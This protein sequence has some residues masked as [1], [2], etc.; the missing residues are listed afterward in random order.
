MSKRKGRQRGTRKKTAALPELASIISPWTDLLCVG[1]LSIVLMIFLLAYILPGYS[2]QRGSGVNLGNVLLLQ[3]LINWPHFMAS[4]RLLYTS[5]KNI[6]HY[7]SSAIYVPVALLLVAGVALFSGEGF[8]NGG[9]RINQEVTYVVWLVAAFYLAWHYTGQAWG[10]IATFSHIHEIPLDRT[11]RLLIR[12]GLR[13]LLVWHVVWGMQDLPEQW[14]GALYPYIPDLL[15]VVSLL[16]LLAF[17]TGVVAFFRLKRRSGKTPTAQMV[18]P[19]L[20]I[21][22]WYLVLYFE[23]GAYIYVQLSHSLQYLIFPL[24]IEMNR[25]GFYRINFQAV[26]QLFWSARYYAI[27]VVSGAVFFYLPGQFFSGGQQQYT[28]AV[29]IASMISIH[30]YFVDSCIWKVSRQDVR[31]S[32]FQHL[33]P[34]NIRDN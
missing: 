1:G 30:H 29:L 23:P 17:I 14:L 31:Q 28:V 20:S 12:G 3:A 22:L 32:L 10:M 16:A 24:R 8:R 33:K 18:A 5:G 34:I 7:R 27:L 4:Y 26:G 6:S 2:P 9:L 21:Y 19:W 11:E 13:I 15:M 25:I